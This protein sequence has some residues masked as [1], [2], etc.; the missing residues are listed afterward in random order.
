MIDLVLATSN[1]SKQSQYAH[2]FS[3]ASLPISVSTAREAGVKGE[4]EENGRSL[5]E[6]ARKKA[7]YVFD[8]LPKGS[9]KWVMSDDSGLFLNALK[10]APGHLS[11]RWAGKD[12]PTEVTTQF[13]L[14]K[15]ASCKDRSALFRAVIVLIDPDQTHYLLS[16]E[17]RGSVVERP[18]GEPRPKF[19]YVTLFMPEGHARTWAEMSTEEELAN[20]HRGRAFERLVEFFQKRLDI[21]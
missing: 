18:R 13:T 5:E 3:R 2:L 19:P 17:V 6:N 7:R 8:K 12:V 16:G 11:A 9:N 1:P 14:Q 20:S 15:M 21:E 10:G 4:A